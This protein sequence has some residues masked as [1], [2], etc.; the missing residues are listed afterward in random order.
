MLMRHA[1]VVS[2][3]VAASATAA[4]AGPVRKAGEWQTVINGG[5]PI[6]TCV[7]EDMPVDEKRSRNRCRAPRRGLQDDEVHHVRRHDRLRDGM[8]DRR[9][10]DDI[11]GHHH[12]VR[13]RAHTKATA[14]A[15]PSQLQRPDH[16][17]ARHG[18]DG[19]LQP[20]G[21]CKPGDQQMKKTGARE[22]TS[23]PLRD[24]P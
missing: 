21:P 15:A 7:P 19:R 6:L 10:Q 12:P 9:Q 5:Q 2:I 17:P 14:T 18:H 23:Q 24:G 22:T 4:W 20:H 3:L 8:H 16:A 1:F 13:P 11:H